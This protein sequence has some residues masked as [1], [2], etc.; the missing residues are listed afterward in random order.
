LSAAYSTIPVISNAIQSHDSDIHVSSPIL[1]EETLYFVASNLGD[2]PGGIS[3]A[4]LSVPG[5]S[6][7]TLLPV[8]SAAA[9]IPTGSKQVAFKPHFRM[10]SETAEQL[11]GSKEMQNT[12]VQPKVT[13]QIVNHNGDDTEQTVDIPPLTVFLLYR[14]HRNRCEVEP[15]KTVDPECR[16]AG[17][18]GDY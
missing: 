13:F 14:N 4:S 17:G 10:S 8:D 6:A 9:F 7:T 16:G 5:D 12:T 18:G 2:R 11:L 3:S 1:S 15:A